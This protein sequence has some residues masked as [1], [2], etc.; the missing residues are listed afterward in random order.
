MRVPVKASSACLCI[1]V[2]ILTRLISS[3]ILKAWLHANLVRQHVSSCL[4]VLREIFASVSVMHSTHRRRGEGTF[5]GAV[6]EGVCTL[7][8][9]YW[10]WRIINPAR[11]YDDLRWH[12]THFRGILKAHNYNTAQTRTFYE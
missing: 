12:Y 1:Q 11:S 2:N 4:K 10:L 7:E 9:I 8:A 5:R 6:E 3:K